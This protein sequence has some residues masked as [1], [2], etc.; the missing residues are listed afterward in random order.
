MMNDK[1]S[2]I[3]TQCI[4]DIEKGEKTVAECIEQY[5]QYKDELVDLLNLMQYVKVNLKEPVDEDFRWRTRSTLVNRVVNH[6]PVT[7]WEKSRL[8]FRET[9]TIRKRKPI[10]QAVLIV[11]VLLSLISGGSVLASENTVPG[12]FLYPLKMIV[13]E[14]RLVIT[15]EE[16]DATLHLQFA[17]RRLR[18]VEALAEKGRYQGIGVAID[19]FENHID[20]AAR[21]VPVDKGSEEIQKDWKLTEFSDSIFKHQAV[22]QGLLEDEVIAVEAREAIEHAI[23]VSK[24]GQLRLSELFP[25]GLPAQP[26]VEPGMPPLPEKPVD[27]GPPDLPTIPTLPVEIPVDLDDLPEDDDEDDGPPF[28]L[29]EPAEGQPGRP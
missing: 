4:D 19:R 20:G 14:A 3:L 13:E 8:W 15:G 16:K 27:P 9:F 7:I 28:P 24:K 25:E 5:P 26:P 10:M 22:L 12:D 11:T 21:S 1:I 17:E 6:Q 23:E 29:P 18:E 2:M